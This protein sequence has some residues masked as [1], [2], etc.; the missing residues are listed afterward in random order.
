MPLVTNFANLVGPQLYVLGINYHRET[1]DSLAI[2]PHDH[3]LSPLNR[4]DSFSVM[5]CEIML[6]CT[7]VAPVLTTLQVFVGTM[8]AAA[9]LHDQALG[10][11]DMLRALPQSIIDIYVETASSQPSA[12]NPFCELLCEG[13]ED[14]ELLPRLQRIWFGQFTTE[15]LEH[16]I[17]A[18][19]TRICENRKI[20]V[21]E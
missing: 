10:G 14:R 12:A 1:L 18:R 15:I 19:L 6:G 8:D 16:S 20:A 5:A 11:Q 13:L 7:I 4:L 21:T 17:K 9:L 3:A 2:Q